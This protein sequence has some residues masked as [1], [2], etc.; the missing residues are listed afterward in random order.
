MAEF[1]VLWPDAGVDKSKKI[2]IQKH[3]F[4][5]FFKHYT[6]FTYNFPIETLFNTVTL[7]KLNPAFFFLNRN[8]Y[9]YHSNQ[10]NYC[11]VVVLKKNLGRLPIFI[12]YHFVS[13]VY[14]SVRIF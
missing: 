5:L 13:I 9:V 12:K 1:R 11:T 10:N 6:L 3:Y 7:F 2:Y 8:F 14:Y 4:V